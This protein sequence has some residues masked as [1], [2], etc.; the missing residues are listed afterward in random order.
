MS[1]DTMRQLSYSTFWTAEVDRNYLP[2][3]AQALLTT[4][5]V[6]KVFKLHTR[7]QREDLLDRQTYILCLAYLNNGRSGGYD[8]SASRPV[9]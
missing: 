2:L 9:V 6:V 5:N 3:V 8:N 4:S 1:Q 7:L